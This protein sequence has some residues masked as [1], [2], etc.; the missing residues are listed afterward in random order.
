MIWSPASAPK[1]KGPILWLS[2]HPSLNTTGNLNQHCKSTLSLSMQTKWHFIWV[3]FYKKSLIIL[4]IFSNQIL[5]SWWYFFKLRCNAI[6]RRKTIHLSVHVCNFLYTKTLC[7]QH[8]YNRS[9]QKRKRVRSRNQ[10]VKRH[11]TPRNTITW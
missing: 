4:S 3:H 1:T 9:P 8:T 2:D 10:L 7:R 11:Q 5:L 6:R